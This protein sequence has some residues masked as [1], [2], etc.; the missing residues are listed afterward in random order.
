MKVYKHIYFDLDKTLWDFEANVKEAFREIFDI[1]RLWDRFPDLENFVKVY[2][3]YNEFLWEKYRNGKIKKN[4]LRTER[5]RL[6]LNQHGINDPALTEK[7]SAAYLEI[8]P[9][10]PVLVENA[11]EVLSFLKPKYRLYILTNGFPEV[12]QSKIQNSGLGPFFDKVITPEHAGWHKP[13]R[14]IFGY[15]LKTVNAKKDE[16]IMVGDDLGTDIIGAKNFGI[17][18][19][20]FNVSGI[21]HN[22]AVTFEI[23]Q[24]KELMD[25]F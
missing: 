22:I 13:D 17:D 5:F 24:F 21:S 18:Q 6:T 25:I 14:R 3:T 1:Y 2:T 7:I 10:K 16:S 11:I 15:A 8:T 23:R 20:F 12:Q 19:V 4:L 9:Q